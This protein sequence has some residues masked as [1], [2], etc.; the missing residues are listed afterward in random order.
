[1]LATVL[2]SPKPT[3]AEREKKE[4]KA[5]FPIRLA[6]CRSHPQPSPRNQASEPGAGSLADCLQKRQ[7][8]ECVRKAKPSLPVYEKPPTILSLPQGRELAGP[9][10][11]HTPE[12][13]R[14]RHV[15]LLW[16]GSVLRTLSSPGGRTPTWR[17]QPAHSRLGPR[18]RRSDWPSAAGAAPR[19]EA[20]PP[21][22]AGT[23]R[24]VA[25]MRTAPRRAAS[26]RWPPADSQATTQCNPHVGPG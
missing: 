6:K 7:H 24:E 12:K 5:A 8:P 16:S 26:T 22:G 20:T 23:R 9:P 14:R 3:N 17:P 13:R 18:C 21:N 2:S 4:G 11:R 10:P 25:A 15:T 1:M 19:Q